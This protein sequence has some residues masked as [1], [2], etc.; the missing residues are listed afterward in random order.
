M[1][2]ETHMRQTKIKR[3][4]AAAVNHSR[5]GEVNN[6]KIFRNRSL[7]DLKKLQE[8]YQSIEIMMP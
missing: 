2:V 7:E 5:A 3:Q 1:A 6:S 4:A 8:R